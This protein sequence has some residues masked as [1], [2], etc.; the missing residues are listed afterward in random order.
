[1][2]Q[3]VCRRGHRTRSL[4]S[5]PM[6]LEPLLE[7]RLRSLALIENLLERRT[8][9]RTPPCAIGSVKTNIGHTYTAGGSGRA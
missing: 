8:N 3:A 6:A 7:I 9:E 5:K 4:T 2:A 1:M